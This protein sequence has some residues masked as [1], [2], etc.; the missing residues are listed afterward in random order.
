MSPPRSPSMNSVVSFELMRSIIVFGIA[1]CGA[2]NRDAVLYVVPEQ[3]HHVS[4]A[5]NQDYFVAV[6]YL[7][8]CRQVLRAVGCYY[9]RLDLRL[10]ELADLLAVWYLCREQRLEQLFR[11]SYY[12]LPPVA[13]R[14][15]DFLYLECGL[16]RPYPVNRFYRSCQYAGI[17]SA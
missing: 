17:N 16:K 13:S 14:V 6:G 15:S 7:R 8:A 4:A 2:A 1:A 5:F 9:A 3:V 10:N 11:P 12:A